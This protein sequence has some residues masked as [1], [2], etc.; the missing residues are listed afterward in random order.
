MVFIALN[1]QIFL[2]SVD[3]D[4]FYNQK[5]TT[6]HRRLNSRYYYKTKLS[7]KR[8]K[9]ENRLEKMEDKQF[10]NYLMY[11]QMKLQLKDIGYKINIINSEIK[12]LKHELTNLLNANQEKRKLKINKLKNKDIVSV[13]DSSLIRY[14]G[15]PYDEF[16]NDMIIVR[17]YYFKVLEDIIKNGFIYG[18]EEFIPFTASAGQIRTK[19]TLFIK[20]ST[21]EGIENQLTCGLTINHINEKGGVNVNKYLAYL[22][23]SNSATDEWTSFNIDK[24]IVVDD[25]ETIVKGLVDFIDSSDYSIT[26]KHMG[27]PIPHTD[28]CGMMLKCVNDKSLMVRLPWVKGLLVPFPFDKFIRE[29]NRKNPNNKCGTVKDIYGKTYNIL[30]DGIEVIFT[31]SQFKMWKYYD[32]WEEYQIKYKK[33]H[34]QAGYCNEE[35]EVFGN[36]KL[37]YQMLQTLTDITVEEIEEIAKVTKDDIYN[38]GTDRNTMLKVLGVTKSNINKNYLQ[39]ALEIYPELLQDTYSKQIIKQTKASMVK[40]A[41]AGKLDINGKYTFL[42]PDLYAFCEYLFLGDK[43]PKGLLG[44]G[45]VSCKLYEDQAR[46]DCLR[47]PHLYREHAVRVNKVDK[48]TKRWFITNG[49]YTSCHDLISKLLQF[50]NDGDT[51]LVVGDELFVKIADRNMQ[52]IVP[53]YYEMKGSKPTT[54]SRKSVYDGLANA[55]AGGNIG[56]I[57]NDVTKIWNSK[58]PSLDA[59]KL[60]TLENNF[61][62][63]YAKTLFKP[64]RP[65]KVHKQIT[66]YTKSKVPYF[67]IYAKDKNRHQV[68]KWNDS[69][70]NMLKKIIPNSPI[71]FRNTNVGKFDYKML[72]HNKNIKVNIH[73]NKIIE[74]YTELDLAKYFMI[75]CTDGKYNNLAFTYKE[76]RKDLLS[77]DDDTNKVVDTLIKYLYKHKKSS[78]KM[79]LWECFGDII[80]DNLKKNIDKPLDDGWI[81]CEKC[82]K[83]ITYYSNRKYCDDCWKEKEQEDNR[84]YARESMRKSRERSKC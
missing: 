41:R 45:E 5:E 54:I 60:L 77:L 48:E 16:T 65:H 12:Q 17:T 28:G 31:K 67:F 56:A 26:R 51:S 82:G 2:Y 23:L 81:M 10:N 72:L 33:Y 36:A 69:T 22:A 13:F 18:K 64:T 68:K 73:N 46:L 80:I 62:I 15:I 1:K 6:I 21:Y 76:I 50:D 19:K 71:V 43:N 8:I 55:Y 24:A 27:V 20:K 40:K 84:R 47:S 25:M 52:G 57:S 74:K 14:M 32:S 75:D 42:I 4:Y 29:H 49:I 9:I 35:P 38:L 30:E 83:R 78:Y 66:E 39:Q 7:N 61:V 63:D 44:D 53:L 34:C 11:E 59:V 79:T 70:V 58:N 37:N 3:T